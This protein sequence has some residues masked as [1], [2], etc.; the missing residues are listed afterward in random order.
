MDS[1]SSATPRVALKKGLL[2]KHLAK[3]ERGRWPPEL[4]GKRS[5]GADRPR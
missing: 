1:L 4:E 5:I 2:D 3:P